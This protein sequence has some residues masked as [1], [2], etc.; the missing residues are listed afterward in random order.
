MCYALI[1]FLVRPL[2]ILRG[3]NFRVLMPF[4]MLHPF[5]HKISLIIFANEQCVNALKRATSISTIETWTLSTYSICINA[6]K[7]ASSISTLLRGNKYENSR[8]VSMP[9]NGLHPFLRN[10]R[11]QLYGVTVYCINALK[12]ASS[13]STKIRCYCQS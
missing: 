10:K 3:T 9:L 1:P 7:R 13:I 11:K 12:R 5:L 4:N 6:L 2:R 8:C